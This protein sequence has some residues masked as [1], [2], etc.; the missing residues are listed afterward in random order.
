MT[1]RLTQPFQPW[2]ENMRK[3]LSVS[4]Q[5]DKVLWRLCDIACKFLLSPKDILFA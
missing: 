1:I 3:I 5:P 2:L 4:V